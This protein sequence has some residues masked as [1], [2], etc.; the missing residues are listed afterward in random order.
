[1][2]IRDRRLVMTFRHFALLTFS[3]IAAN[4]VAFQKGS[5]HELGR[6][7]AYEPYGR[8]SDERVSEMQAEPTRTIDAKSVEKDAIPTLTVTGEAEL[9]RPADQVQIRLGVVTD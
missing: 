3:M 6:G 9:Q 2:C 8:N 4:A 7:D 1:M 5:S